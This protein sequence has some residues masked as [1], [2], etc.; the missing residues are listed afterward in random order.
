MAY[1][2]KL[3]LDNKVLSVNSVNNAVITDSNGVE[4]EQLGIN[5]LESLYGWPNWKQ[6]SYN[7]FGGIYYNTDPIT[8]VKT[9]GEDQSKAFRANY[10]GINFQYD[11]INNVFYAP[12]PLDINGVE[13]TSWT[14]SAPTWIWTAPIPYPSDNSNTYV[15]NEST[16]SWEIFVP[17]S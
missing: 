9:L 12:I 7:T 1:F 13:C 2:A 5:F 8:G 16:Q 17:N 10:A 6:T 11:E 14:V 3:N 15:W 4:Q